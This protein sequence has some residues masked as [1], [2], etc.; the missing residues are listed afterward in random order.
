MRLAP[1]L[2]LLLLTSPVSGQWFHDSVETALIPVRYGGVGEMRTLLSTLVPD[3]YYTEKKRAL[4][5][6]GSPGAVTQVRELL[7]ELDRPLNRVM[8]DI[9]LLEASAEFDRYMKIERL[10][11][12]DP[13]E[14]REWIFPCRPPRERS[15]IWF[16]R[17]TFLPNKAAEVAILAAQPQA[18]VVELDKLDLT[19]SSWNGSRKLAKIA[20]ETTLGRD[21]LIQFCDPDDNFGIEI[22]L[23]PER[24][25]DSRL[26]LTMRP[27]PHFINRTGKPTRRWTTG[28]YETSDGHTLVIGGL[29]DSE[30]IESARRHGTGP[31]AKKLAGVKGPV[32]MLVTASLVR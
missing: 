9:R 20:V 16:G 32:L 22:D 18:R 25:D 26:W 29:V 19:E 30:I 7:A 12:Q 17:P 5:V 13:Q 31:V 1:L 15:E 23:K 4:L 28:R 27:A 24:I 6:Y 11:A 8:V 3:V 21:A 14:A 2:I 10:P